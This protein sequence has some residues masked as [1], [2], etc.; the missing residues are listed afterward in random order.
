MIT[1][2]K[3]GFSIELAKAIKNG[4]YSEYIEILDTLKVDNRIIQ[5]MKENNE[6]EILMFEIQYYINQ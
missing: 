2:L 5:K 3:E 4:N 1:M 6:N